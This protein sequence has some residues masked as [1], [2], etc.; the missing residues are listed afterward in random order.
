MD[1]D[2][3]VITHLTGVTEQSLA[4][5]LKGLCLASSYVLFPFSLSEFELGL[6][7]LENI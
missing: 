1:Y 3:P 5:I 2:V 7:D 4:F 6:V